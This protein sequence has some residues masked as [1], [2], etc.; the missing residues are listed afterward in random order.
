MLIH[1]PR[2]FA[3]MSFTLI[4][5]LIVVA[6]IGILAAIAVP[7]FLNAQLRARVARTQADQRSIGTALSCY[8]IDNNAF[9]PFVNWPEFAFRGVPELTTP[10]SYIADYPVDPFQ[11]AKEGHGVPETIKYVKMSYYNIRIMGRTGQAR[12]NTSFAVE[13]ERQGN[14]WVLRSFGPDRKANYDSALDVYP[15][16][17]SSNGLR[18]IGDIYLVGS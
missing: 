13:W 3:R 2:R 8:N 12:G 6:I 1:L 17:D 4:E 7:N 9:P 15:G 5:L 10:V 16:Y 14:R 11:T 18:S